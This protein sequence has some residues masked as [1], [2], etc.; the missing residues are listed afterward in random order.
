MKTRHIFPL[1]VILLASLAIGV[2]SASAAD[3]DLVGLTIKN[4]TDRYVFVSL[5]PPEGPTVYF[6]AV[7]AGETRDFTVPRA[8][9]T[10]T[11][12]ACGLSA[13]GSFEINRFTTLVF[14]PCDRAPAN[15]GEVSFEKIH[16]F[17]SP[18]RGDFTYQME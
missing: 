9:Y 11:T 4:R 16:L 12:V 15:P 14:T 1:L 7:P 6:L 17:D 3:E 18:D 5:L 10:H 8:V 2:L 13:A